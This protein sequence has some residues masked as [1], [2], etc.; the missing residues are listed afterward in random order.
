MRAGLYALLGSGFAAAA[1]LAC[2]GDTTVAPSDG[3]SDATTTDAPS[4]APAS[5]TGTG[6]GGDAGSWVPSAFG[7]DLV[8]WL[9]GD[10]GLGLDDAGA[11]VSWQDQSL[12]PV[13]FTGSALTDVTPNGHVVVNFNATNV[14]VQTASVSKLE[15][16]STDDFVIAAVMQT[17]SGTTSPPGAYAFFKSQVFGLK[18]GQYLGDGIAVGSDISGTTDKL[19]IW[20]KG[21]DRDAGT[22]FLSS[23][24][25]SD[26]AYHVAIA[27][28]IGGTSLHTKMDGV[29]ETTT[30]SQPVDISQPTVPLSIGNVFWGEIFSGTFAY[31][32]AEL[33]VVRRSGSFSVQEVGQ[34]E[35]YLRTKYAAK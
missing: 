23:K 2:V 31:K 7:V 9:E 4:D 29:E 12:Y 14:N 15:L 34:L 21:S 16:G 20:D 27:R 28:R 33:V 10:V 30:L 22:D 13:T 17:T 8:L 11:V 1:F 35:N 3:G 19:E 26:G 6:D 18:P 24:T 5:E 32:L 25:F